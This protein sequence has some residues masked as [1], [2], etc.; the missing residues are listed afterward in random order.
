MGHGPDEAALGVHLRVALAHAGAGRVPDESCSGR[1]PACSRPRPAPRRSSSPPA[2]SP[3]RPSGRGHPVGAGHPAP[4]LC[5][6]YA[7][8]YLDAHV[9]PPLGVEL[10]WLPTPAQRWA[11]TTIRAEAGDTLLLYTDGLLDAHATVGAGLGVDSL[12]ARIAGD[13]GTGEPVRT[14]LPAIA[15]AAPRQSSDDVAMVALEV[16]RGGG[17]G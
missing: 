8:R 6:G 13:L 15:R 5:S 11:P 4:I 10:P 7:A 9:G 1:W 16:G 12:I 2:T 14:W 3:S 17:S